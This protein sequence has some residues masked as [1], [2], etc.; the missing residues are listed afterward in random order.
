[1]GGICAVEGTFFF[2]FQVI[3]PENDRPETKPGTLYISALLN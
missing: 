2:P 1:V 3:A